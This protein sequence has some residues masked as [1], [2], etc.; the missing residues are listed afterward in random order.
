VLDRQD[1]WATQSSTSDTLALLQN[2]HIALFCWESGVDNVAVREGLACV[3]LAVCDGRRWNELRTKVY[4]G[5]FNFMSHK[6][7]LFAQS[8]NQNQR[9]DDVLIHYSVDA[10]HTF[11]IG[12][13]SQRVAA[14]LSRVSVVE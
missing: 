10:L 7:L 12:S 4:A 13:N 5:K 11:P 14:L 1:N 6:S 8:G 2:L 3:P 9:R